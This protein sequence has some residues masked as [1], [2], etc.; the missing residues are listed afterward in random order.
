MCVCLYILEY[1]W[2][3]QC[4]GIMKQKSKMKISLIFLLMFIFHLQ[5]LPFSHSKSIVTQLP[6][7]SGKLPFTIE[8]GYVCI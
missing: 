3:D 6:G 4:E 7:F 8:T 5:M 2:I 1:K